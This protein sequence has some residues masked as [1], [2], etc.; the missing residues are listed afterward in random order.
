[1]KHF[2][3]P[4]NFIPSIVGTSLLLVALA[5]ARIVLSQ[6]QSSSAL[7]VQILRDKVKADKKLMV[8]S[9][10]ELTDAEAEVFWPIYDSYQNELIALNERLDKNLQCYADAYNADKLTDQ[11]AM[12]VFDEDLAIVEAEINLRKVYWTKLNVVLPGI[13]AARFL[14]IEDKIRAQLRYELANEV[15]LI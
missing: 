3:S 2:I 4:Q 10:M 7:N 8:A 15:P 5:G 14:Q 1:M 9:Y 11:I 13:K 12:K 6:D